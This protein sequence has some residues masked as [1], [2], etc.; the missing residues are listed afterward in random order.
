MC[1]SDIGSI[2]SISRVT[3]L[4]LSCTLPAFFQYLAQSLDEMM[5]TITQSIVD[6]ARTMKN[7]NGLLNWTC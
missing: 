1:L 5:E 2:S 4:N 3:L 6:I 7:K